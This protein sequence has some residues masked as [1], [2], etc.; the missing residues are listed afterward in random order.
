MVQTWSVGSSTVAA[1]GENL[2]ICHTTGQPFIG[3]QQNNESQIHAGF[4]FINGLE[5]VS[6][7]VDYLSEELSHSYPLGQNY[8]NPFNPSTQI[9]FELPVA[10]DVT[11]EIFDVF[12]R[13]VAVLLQN[14]QKQAGY[15]NVSFDASDLSSGMYIYRLHAQGSSVNAEIPLFKPE[16]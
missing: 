11:L 2:I 16:K 9:R 13:R 12:G 5:N 1:S 4:H 14:E 15:H 3:V 10:A 6:T 7:S 8:P